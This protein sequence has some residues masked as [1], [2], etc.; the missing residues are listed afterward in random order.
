MW[1]IHCPPNDHFSDYFVTCNQ[2]VMLHLG[3]AVVNLP[4]GCLIRSR[5][6][7]ILLHII[8][9]NSKL[10]FQFTYKRHW[11]NVFFKKWCCLRC[12]IQKCGL[13]GL[14]WLGQMSWTVHTIYPNK[15]PDFFQ[16]CYFFPPKTLTL[17]IFI[18]LC[19]FLFS[20]D[21]LFSFLNKRP[22]TSS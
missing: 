14:M 21:E 5:M 2:N 7:S 19:L 18:L 8:W 3:R 11:Q 4:S 6:V 17:C 16:I 13:I 22:I 1:C 10:K 20:F 15:T 9:L 12:K